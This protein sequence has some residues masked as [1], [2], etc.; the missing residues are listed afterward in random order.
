MADSTKED[1]FGRIPLHWAA[2]DGNM[3]MVILL[4]SAGSSTL[5]ID[6]DGKSPADAAED[7]GFSLVAKYI[8]SFSQPGR[9]LM[10]L[11][12]TLSL[13]GRIMSWL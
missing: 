7:H 13:L 11:Q 1:I 2:A 9:P 8:R 3:P 10:P 12:D 6:H 4:L 5:S